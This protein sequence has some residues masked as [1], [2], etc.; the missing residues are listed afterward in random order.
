[1]ESF[2]KCDVVLPGRVTAPQCYDT[3]AG[4]CQEP[5][6]VR[7]APARLLQRALKVRALHRIGRKW[8]VTAEPGLIDATA[9]LFMPKGTQ[10]VRIASVDLL[11]ELHFLQLKDRSPSELL[12]VSFLA[13]CAGCVAWTLGEGS[14]SIG[15]VD[16]TSRGTCSIC[17][18]PCSMSGIPSESWAHLFTVQTDGLKFEEELEVSPANLPFGCDQE[19]AKLWELKC[20]SP[21]ANW[22]GVSVECKIAWCNMRN[23]DAWQPGL[24]QLPDCNSATIL[25]PPEN[26]AKSNNEVVIEPE[27]VSDLLSSSAEPASAPS[28]ST[29]AAPS[30]SQKQRK[31]HARY[32][33]EDPT[34]TDSM[35]PGI[36]AF[37]GMLACSLMVCVG[38]GSLL[39]G[40]LNLDEVDWR[41]D[42]SAHAS[43][44]ERYSPTKRAQA[45][46][47]RSM[48]GEFI[49]VQP[50]PTIIATPQTSGATLQL[51]IQ[52][53]RPCTVIRNMDS[54]RVFP[55]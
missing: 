38:C 24:H 32:A 46:S 53:T 50:Q 16:L 10:I 5:R 52:K 39:R 55:Q 22:G 34:E 44:I 13:P 51:P 8:T 21:D 1:M 18:T 11:Q 37:F 20:G 28:A 49:D 47:A 2:S 6:T 15:Q 19:E 43:H 26:S 29:T 35:V 54:F 7:T 40:H 33:T 17:F 23:C 3:A 12:Q 4:L 14:R 45:L 27:R 48:P 25:T 36:L 9:S 30:T 42:G 31:I 41:S